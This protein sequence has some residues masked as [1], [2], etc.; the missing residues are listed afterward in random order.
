MSFLKNIFKKEAEVERKLTHANQLKKNDI[1]VLS[2]SFGLP[3]TLRGQEFQVSAINCYEYESKT[4]TEWVLK[5][6]NNT[7]I[8]LTL[9]IDDE[10]YLK[11]SLKIERNDVETLF[12]L[13]DFATIFDEPGNAFLERQADSNSTS[14]WSSD[15]YQQQTYSQVGYFHRK[16]NRVES[17]SSY[18]G[19]DAGEQFELYALFDKEDTRG[20]DIEV[21]QDGDT[22]VFLT[23]F[24]PTTDIIDMY[25][26]S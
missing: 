25:P 17:L 21:W 4:E 12:N 22:E 3:E 23:L 6:T 1:I 20:I 2:D 11:F 19:K 5:G 14:Q 24:R 16:D 9:D 7:Q 15:Q 13:D 10:T 26:G 8:Y 18:E